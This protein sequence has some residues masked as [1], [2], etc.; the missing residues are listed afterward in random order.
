MENSKIEIYKRV[1][2]KFITTLSGPS[3][4]IRNAMLFKR[5]CNKKT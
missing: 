3:P 4:E 5:R 2:P 1:G